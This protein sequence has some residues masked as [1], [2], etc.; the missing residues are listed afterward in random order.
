MP[1]INL[2]YETSEYLSLAAQI[3]KQDLAQIGITLTLQ[4]VSSNTYLNLESVPGT[5]STAPY[6]MAG[7][8]TGWPDF[9]GYEFIVASE[10]GVYNFL[11]NQTIYNMIVQSNSQLNT[12]LRAQEISQITLDVKQQ[13]AFIWLG[14]DLD[15]YPTGDSYGPIVW[16]SC[17]VGQW[18]SVNM[19]G[20]DFNALSYNCSPT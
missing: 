3:M 14:Q 8:W 20:P 11:Q 15:L 13:A 1:S 9:S 5:N 6:M 10:Y 19:D 16:N 7:A 18:Y 4:E 2:V 12:T 17:V